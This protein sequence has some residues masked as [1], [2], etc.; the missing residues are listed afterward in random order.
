MSVGQVCS[1]CLRGLGRHL[2]PFHMPGPPGAPHAAT[3]VCSRLALADSCLPALA[4]C[5]LQSGHCMSFTLGTET[6]SVS[7]TTPRVLT[8]ACG[9]NAMV[10]LKLGVS[11]FSAWVFS[12]ARGV[13]SKERV[14]VESWDMCPVTK[15]LAGPAG[16]SR[17]GQRSAGKCPAQPRGGLQARCVRRRVGSWQRERVATATRLGRRRTCSASGDMGYLRQVAVA[18]MCSATWSWVHF[19]ELLAPCRPF[20]L[21]RP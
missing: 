18:G 8:D 19:L 6:R 9:V 7:G 17:Y 11:G 3:W 15:A 1:Q 10:P 2:C 16:C 4:T 20:F 14:R 5:R 13:S 12:W 21:N